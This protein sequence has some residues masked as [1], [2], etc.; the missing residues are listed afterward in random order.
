M[1]ILR[2][3]FLGIFLATL[4]AAFSFPTSAISQ[5]N[6]VQEVINI[7]HARIEVRSQVSVIKYLGTSERSH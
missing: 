5:T 4:G 1:D 2:P 3:R 6:V 7:G